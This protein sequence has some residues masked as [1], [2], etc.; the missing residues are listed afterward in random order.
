MLIY[1]HELDLQS[2]IFFWFYSFEKLKNKQISKFQNLSKV[3]KVWRDANKYCYDDGD[4]YLL[5]CI[6]HVYECRFCY[7]QCWSRINRLVYYS[8]SKYW[9]L[10][11]KQM[12]YACFADQLIFISLEYY[13]EKQN[14]TALA[15]FWNISAIIRKKTN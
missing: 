13:S 3:K 2:C 9:A 5:L 6:W 10:N 12:I 14:F 15:H 11:S 8:R 1:H 4:K 7:R